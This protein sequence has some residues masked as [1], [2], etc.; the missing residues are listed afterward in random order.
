MVTVDHVLVNLDIDQMPIGTPHEA[1]VHDAADLARLRL[2]A[3]ATAPASREALA[4]ATANRS[5]PPNVV[6][7]AVVFDKRVPSHVAE[8]RDWH[9]RVCRM[10]LPA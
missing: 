10:P 6:Y 7:V 1:A 2:R 3:N 4:W 9:G 5:C 8:F